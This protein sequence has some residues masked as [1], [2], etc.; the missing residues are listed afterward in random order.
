MRGTVTP[1]LDPLELEPK[2]IQPSLIRLPTG[3]DRG[4]ISTARFSATTCWARSPSVREMVAILSRTYWRTMG[5]N[6][7]LSSPREK[8]WIQERIGSPDKESP[9]TREGTSARS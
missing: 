2:P 9:S 8:G 7:A 5:P 3:F 6:F 1:K 4:P